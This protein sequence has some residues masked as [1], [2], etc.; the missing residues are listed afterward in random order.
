[1][2][3]A[4]PCGSWPSPL[5]VE[6]AAGAQRRLMQPRLHAGAVHWL[7]G[8]PQEGGRVVWMREQEGVV[9][10]LTP[11]PFSVRSRAHEYGGGAHAP[12][13]GGLFFCNDT[14]QCIYRIEEGGPR[15]ITEPGPR[16]YA[17]I[18]WDADRM[19]LLCVC[20]DTSG[21]RPEDM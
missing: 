17:D 13:D 15:R 1:M 3:R 5:S 11:L 2:R 4:A 12:T 8:R 9:Q 7:E 19:R 16:R 18:S 10:A 6:Q 20:E 14:D 21:A